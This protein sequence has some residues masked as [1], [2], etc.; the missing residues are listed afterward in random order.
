[1]STNDTKPKRGER[2][3]AAPPPRLDRLGA[4]NGTE[5]GVP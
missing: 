5:R 1:M 4:G 3:A 2:P